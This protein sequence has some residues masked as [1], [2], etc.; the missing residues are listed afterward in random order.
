MNGSRTDAG[1]LGTSAVRRAVAVLVLLATASGAVAQADS[2][3]VVPDSGA[4]A[5]PSVL[6]DSLVTA[7][8]PAQIEV[9]AP[10][11]VLRG[12]PFAV[13]V[14][15]LDQ[16]EGASIRVGGQSVPLAAGE[17]GAFTASDLRV[18]DG[19]AT[20]E[21]VRG[22]AVIGAA[23]PRTLPGWVSILPPLL[24]IVVAL[25]FRRVI[26]ALF[27]GIWTGALLIEGL[28]PG[29]LW[30]GLFDTFQVYIL[31]AMTDEGHASIILFTFMIGGVV[32]IIQ[33][34][35][36]TQGVVNGIV[37]W[38]NTPKRGQTATGLLGLAIFFDDYAN[39]LIIGNTMRPVTDRLRISREKLAYIVDST[40]APVASL[41]LVT[42]WIG[43]EVG[44]INEAVAG[45]PG[46]TLD[47]Y[48]IFLES[49]LYRFYPILALFFVFVIAFTDREFGPMYDAEHRA[50]TTGAVLGPD[51]KVDDAA[52]DG[53]VF[54]PPA[55]KPHR[56]L[57]A[58]VPILVLVFG[59]LAGLWVTGEGDTVREVI[60]SAD[61][62]KALMWS[63]LAAVLVALAM[64]IGQRI[65]TLDEAIDSWYEGG[66]G[67]LLATIILLMAW[68]LSATT[69][70]LHTGDYLGTALSAALPPGIVPALIF[71]LAAVTAFATGTSWGTMG[72]LMPLVV[73]LMWGV[74]EANGI[75]DP[76]H[77]YLLYS[78]VSCVLAGAVWGDH[79][80]PISDTT[81]LSSMASGCDHLAH[82]RT[83]LP[84]A[85]AVGGA[86]LLLGT[87]PTGFGFPWWL[88][89][90]L[91]AAVLFAGLRFFGRPVVGHNEVVE[92]EAP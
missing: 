17:D 30:A 29:G 9:T 42:T 41:A 37:R 10:D 62:Y 6:R 21:V 47:G 59:V 45:I 19:P 57:N 12:V 64:S 3:A 20:V 27:L 15:G 74:M 68:A 90:L 31:N 1:R 22:G 32:G 92:M 78:A 44:L 82:V 52:A 88:S 61:S 39:S 14:K 79:C 25:L 56:A 86:A 63:S 38:A 48:G 24:A 13:T 75:A 87:I 33:K 65:L 23:T 80:S 18:P 60:G 66:K 67:M 4:I 89:L 54:V 77:M 84:Y 8:P 83:Q 26:P 53:D 58:I 72:I 5:A 16:A 91:G 34:N 71:V 46:L 49:I 28:T 43:F 36:G 85:L 51:A 73:R 69:D 76:E 11:I 2:A 50:R 35:G 70:V 81:I 40:S 7:A 55:G